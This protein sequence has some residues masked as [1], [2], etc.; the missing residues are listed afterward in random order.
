MFVGRAREL[1]ALQ[2][3]LDAARAGHGAGVLVAGEAGVGKTRLVSELGAHAEGFEVRLGR[4]LDLVGTELPYQPFAEALGGLPEREASSQLRLF[5]AVLAGLAERAPALLVLEDL[6]WADASTLDLVVFLAHN[7]HDRSVLLVGTYRPNEPATAE[8]MRRL[9]EG[10][11]RSGAALAVEL[12]PLAPEE[13]ATLLTARGG[14]PELTD[15]I[16]ARS[17]GNPFFAEELLA[18]RG[19]ALP[20]G[21]RELLLQ[22]VARLDAPTQDLL[23]LAAAAGRDVPFALLR[24]TT[25]LPE[26]ALRAALRAAVDHGV[27]VGDQAAGSFGFRHALLAEAVYA[28][29]LPG[30]REALHAR[31]AE[32]LE[33]RAAAAE[34]APHWAAA[35]RAAEALTASVMAAREAVAVFGLAEALRHLERALVL[36]DD[37]PDAAA[38]ATLD[39][40]ALC[41][42]AAELAGHV[43]RAPRAVELAERAIRL[44]GREDPRRASR[45]HVDLAQ[46][47]YATGRD[48]A[49]LATL[50][51][52]VQLATAVPLSAERAFALGSLAG[53]LM[54]AGR[55]R[56]SLPLAERALA[57]AR[58]TGASAAEVRALTVVG[59]DLAYLGR[60]EEGLAYFHDAVR[61]AEEIGDH[62]GLARGYTNLTDALTMLGRYRES[63]RTA[64]VGL[65]AMRRYGIAEALLFA[66]GIEALLAIGEWDDADRLSAD[67]LRRITASFP[68]WLLVIRAEVEIGRGELD[69]ARVHLDAARATLPEDH[70]FGLYEASLAEL[71]LWEYR[72]TDAAV[73]IDD[74]LSHARGSAAPAPISVQLCAKGLRAQA[75]LATLARARRDA[76]ALEDRLDRARALRAL[77]RRAADDG[78]PVTPTAAGWQ[79]VAEAE[80]ERARGAAGPGLW[81]AAA[82]TWDRLDRSP[83]AAYCRWR[84]AEAL[85]TASAPRAEAAAPLREA[86]AVAQRLGA[87]PLLRELEL[88]AKRARLDLEPLPTGPSRDG[89]TEQLGLTPRESEVLALVARGLTNREIAD[90]LVISVKTASVHVSHILRKLDAPNRLEAATIAHRLAKPI[91]AQDVRSPSRS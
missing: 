36:W 10:V 35:G 25:A 75:E 24:A 12:G 78:S 26:E 68:Y 8:G 71:A 23:R 73:A 81:A 48:A 27:L 3:A 50:E 42:W 39:L 29:I 82:D 61:L 37:V 6:H 7:L 13:L 70:A 54:M 17:E 74:A 80:H 85:A 38:C 84:Q 56:E 89:L 22:R 91:G 88:L 77:A 79:A 14:A 41:S 63:A 33:G 30:E 90:T 60:A 32:Q 28:T 87:R 53:G 21:L 20:R 16:V 76:G 69:A 65:E 18:V 4:C 59:G 52:A 19:G 47:L 64:Q 1:G 83:L 57:L 5:E 44:V 31:L 62:L 2:R 45:L 86:N 9:A 66:N 58:E 43:G 51:R 34:L 72:W 55:R 46:Y 15:A 40:A 49:G 67:A 11:R